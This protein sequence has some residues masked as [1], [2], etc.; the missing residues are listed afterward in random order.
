MAHPRRHPG[1]DFPYLDVPVVPYVPVAVAIL[2]SFLPGALRL[3][4]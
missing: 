3:F 1:E 2:F 4:D